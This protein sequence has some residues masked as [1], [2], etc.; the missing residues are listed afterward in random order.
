MGKEGLEGVRG[1]YGGNVGTE[2][3]GWRKWGGDEWRLND[4]TRE[5]ESEPENNW[6]FPVFFSY[7][8]IVFVCRSVLIKS[9][10]SLSLLVSLL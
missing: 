10:L 9:S 4:V 7:F 6:C 5:E 2:F 8:S 3:E 1:K